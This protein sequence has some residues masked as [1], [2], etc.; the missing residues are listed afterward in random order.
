MTTEA[1]EICGEPTDSD[2][3]DGH[4]HF[5]EPD[6][7]SGVTEFDGDPAEAEADLRRASDDLD[8]ADIDLADTEAR[9]EAIEEEPFDG[10]PE[11]EADFSARME[12][13]QREIEYL[14]Q[15]VSDAQSE[16]GR[17][18]QHW[19]DRGYLPA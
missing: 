14:Q 11:A 15:V 8:K 19:V 9:A 3:I 17:T 18:H 10:S 4:G 16:L 13:V 7:G 12:V 5:S 1:C 6:P 2:E